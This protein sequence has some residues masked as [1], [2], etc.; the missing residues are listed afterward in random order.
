MSTLLRDERGNILPMAASGV[1]VMAALIGGAV[2]MSRAYQAQ[3]RLQSA[4]DAG[5]LAGRRAV[6]NNGFD[7]AAQDQARRYFNMNFDE[8]IQGTDNTDLDIETDV[9]GNAITATASTEMPMLLMQIFGR[10]DM[11][12]SVSCSSTMGVGNS[13][14]TMVLDVTGSMG[15][16]LSGGGTR[17]SALKT[18]V[19]NFYSTV[20]LATQN[21]NARIRYA[22]VPFSTTVNVGELLYDKDPDYLVDQWTI[23]SRAAVDRTITETV[24]VGWE[25]PV[26]TSSTSYGTTTNSGRTQY[27]STNY[28]SLSSCNAARPADSAWANNGAATTTTGTTVN[29]S[30]QQVVTTTVT[31][32]EKQRRYECVLSSGRYRINYRD[33]YRNKLTYNYN[34]SDPITETRTRTEFDRFEYRPVSYDVSLFKRFEDVTTRTGDLGTDEVSR[35]DGCIEE[36][37]TVAQS[38]FSFNALTGMSPSSAFDLDVDSAPTA[39]PATKWAPMWR[40]VAYRRSTIAPS[41]SGTAA[42][43]SCVPRAQLLR[44]MEQGEFNAYADSLTAQGNTYLSIGMLWGARL[45]SPDG[46]FGDLVKDD[47]ANGGSV[48][49][50]IIFMTDGA[51]ESSS[52]IYHAYGIESLD[53]RVS[54]DGT[55]SQTDSRHLS[56][57][58]A[59][60]DA[61]KA[62]G[63]RIWAIAFTTGLT[64]DL[65]YCASANSAYTASDANQLNSAFQEIAKQVGE[66]RVLQ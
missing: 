30:G 57:F 65:R 60:C 2:D 63:I 43:S 12:L 61:V 21:S 10:Q 53:R 51:Q 5:V 54:S 31:P 40:D 47:P 28:S 64:S 55:T 49:R 19:K 24:T 34:T 6:T 18:A 39:D 15:T 41:T 36:R 17:L 50:H 3:S 11:A 62:K 59:I 4:C 20:D 58:R 38:S 1:L 66:L 8:D 9:S 46:I 35:W 44:T 14:V 56:R 45:T 29:G 13:D 23:Q 33:Y 26:V 16:S 48:Q 32:P 7:Q 27:S 37:Q 42:S 22:F 52:S 25:D